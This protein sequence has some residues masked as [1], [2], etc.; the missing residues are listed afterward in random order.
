MEQESRGLGSKPSSPQLQNPTWKG[1]LPPPLQVMDQWRRLISRAPGMALWAREKANCAASALGRPEVAAEIRAR[2]RAFIEVLFGVVV[3]WVVT[4]SA[5]R[6][7]GS[8]ISIASVV[9]E[10]RW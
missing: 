3:V 4:K 5:G 1:A 7:S 2:M 8:S 9:R 6:A 10:A